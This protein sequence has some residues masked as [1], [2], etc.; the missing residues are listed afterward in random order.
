MY[1]YL[2]YRNIYCEL[3][4]G[5]EITNLIDKHATIEAEVPVAPAIVPCEIQCIAIEDFYIRVRNWD[6]N[7]IKSNKCIDFCELYSTYQIKGDLGA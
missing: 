5:N 3:W 2:R 7:P 1:V 6:N 4:L